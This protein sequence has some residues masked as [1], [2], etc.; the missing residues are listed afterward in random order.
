[1]KIDVVE[2]ELI[3]AAKLLDNF[4]HNIAI[5]GSAR[6]NQEHDLAKKAYQ[7]GKLLSDNEFNILT[8]AGPGIM[9][10]A[11]QGAF[12]G[13]SSSIGL[14]IKL[15]KAQTHNPYLD[16][17]LLFEHFFTRKVML[18]KYADACVFFSGG[19]G[20]TDELMEVLTLIQ[21]RKGRRIKIFLLGLSFW[22]PIITWFKTLE[23]QGY[24]SQ[25]D[26]NSF[27]LVDEIAQILT[28][29]KEA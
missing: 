8:G 10:A 11:N 15:P 28:S 1:M 20:T 19:F 24:I 25:Q 3:N 13:K 26:L 16:E 14:N 4:S 21:T 23:Q 22:S 2:S 7:L 18:I 6:I 9:Q 17:C 27:C 12:D 29:I 5:F